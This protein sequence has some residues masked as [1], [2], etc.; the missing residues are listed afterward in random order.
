MKKFLQGKKT[1]LIA[2]AAAVLLFGEMAGMWT[3]PVEVWGFLGVGGAASLRAGI[4]K[5]KG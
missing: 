5:E 3:V 1:Y 2:A 4:E